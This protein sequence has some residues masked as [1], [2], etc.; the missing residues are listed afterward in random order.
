ME[1]Q[2]LEDFFAEQRKR[3]LTAGEACD[4]QGLSTVYDQLATDFDK[5]NMHGNN[6]YGRKTTW[7]NEFPLLVV[8]GSLSQPGLGMITVI[9]IT[10]TR[11]GNGK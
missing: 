8:P 2:S 6:C 7:D 1:D 4:K 10:I 5:V 11:N 3:Y 9:T